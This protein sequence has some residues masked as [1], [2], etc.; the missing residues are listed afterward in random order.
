[1]GGV[2]ISVFLVGRRSKA[3]K[4]EDLE[5]AILVSQWRARK[6]R[7]SASLVCSF[8]GVGPSRVP[9]IMVHRIATLKLELLGTL[10][11]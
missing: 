6:S 3:V 2:W 8:L 11:M 7:K 4:I 1:M 9:L 10:S 5:S